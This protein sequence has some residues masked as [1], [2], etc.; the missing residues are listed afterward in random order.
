MFAVQSADALLN[1]DEVICRDV[2]CVNLASLN[3]ILRQLRTGILL[4]AINNAAARTSYSV[5]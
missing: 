1:V 4:V 3:S 2:S 5:A